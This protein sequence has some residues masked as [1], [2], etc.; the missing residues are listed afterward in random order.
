MELKIEEQQAVRTA[1]A[2]IAASPMFRGA[3]RQRRFLEYIVEET[4][5]GRGGRVNGYALG[6]EVFDRAVDFDPT[7]DAIVRVEAGRLR[8]KLVEYYSDH[9]T[10]DPV[11][12]GLPRGHYVPEFRFPALRESIASAPAGLNSS[13]DLAHRTA[14]AVLP[15]QNLNGG[16]GQDYFC[17]GLADD[18]IA[19]LSKVT[20]LTVLTR[21]AAFRFKGQAVEPAVIAESL[22]VDYLLMGSVRY[23][24]SR[25][26]VF[27]Q[28]IDGLSARA[29]WAER[30]DDTLANVFDMQ[31]RLVAA[32]ATFLKDTLAPAEH[33]R[34]TQ[35]STR[36]LAAFDEYMKGAY[37]AGRP[38]DT[39]N[40]VDLAATHFKRAYELDP[41]FGEPVARLSRLEA[42]R[43]ANWLDDPDVLRARALHYAHEA[44]RIS[45]DSALCNAALAIAYVHHRRYDDAITAAARASALEPGSPEVMVIYG[46]VLAQG[47]DPMA[48]RALL[49]PALQAEKLLN[50]VY[51]WASGMLYFATEEYAKGRDALVNFLQKVPMF[52]A[53][54]V[55]LIAHYVML[56]DEANAIEQARFAYRHAPRMPIGAVE[57]AA[58]LNWRDLRVQARL[59]DAL[60]RGYALAGITLP[61]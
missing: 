43:M 58:Y 45:P 29:L 24:E 19:A 16:P 6:I 46:L 23:A 28:L 9:G 14:L 7:T 8:S 36:N 54:N 37:I 38:N 61:E 22:N 12:I 26:R 47:G 1:V 5:H 34:L 57:Q 49:E 18:L 56:G 42:Y 10:K 17:D 59:R 32:V 2:A 51:A 53:G 3:A 44:V 35:R 11:Q 30:Y 48:G 13:H 33:D 21:F 31:D 60:I 40:W 55:V 39:P 20:G 27:L 25:I 4:L 15:L 52:I 50:P 41:G